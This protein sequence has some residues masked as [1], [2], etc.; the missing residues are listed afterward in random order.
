MIKSFLIKEI[1]DKWIID[2]NYGFYIKN[3]K[4]ILNFHLHTKISRINNLTVIMAA[5]TQIL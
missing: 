5:T 2:R 4:L 1:V 3:K